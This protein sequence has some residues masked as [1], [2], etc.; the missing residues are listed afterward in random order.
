MVNQILI[1][2]MFRDSDTYVQFPQTVEECYI[3]TFIKELNCEISRDLSPP[4]YLQQKENSKD[5]FLQLQ[6]L[7]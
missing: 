4:I 3:D 2:A 5:S 6:K 1:D 7:A